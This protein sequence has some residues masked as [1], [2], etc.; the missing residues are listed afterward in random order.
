M[1]WLNQ[2]KEWLFS[3]IGVA[4]PIAI[5]SIIFKI[6]FKQDSVMM[7]QKGGRRAL[8]IVALLIGLPILLLG[9]WSRYTLSE[10]KPNKVLYDNI[11]INKDEDEPNSIY[12]QDDDLFSEPTY[13][14]DNFS[15]ESERFL[16]LYDDFV[17]ANIPISRE[18]AHMWYLVFSR[19][20]KS[21]DE[22]YYYNAIDTQIPKELYLKKFE[23]ITDLLA[24]AVVQNDDA[25]ELFL[26]CINDQDLKTIDAFFELV[27]EYLLT[28]DQAFQYELD[29]LINGYLISYYF[30]D[31]KSKYMFI[32]LVEAYYEAGVVK[33]KEGV[34]A[35][36]KDSPPGA[37]YDSQI[38]VSFYVYIFGPCEIMQR[39]SEIHQ[40]WRNST[41]YFE[42]KYE[43]ILKNKS[44]L[45]LP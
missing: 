38:N 14:V 19:I 7:T 31:P 5:I 13:E 26:T 28:N 37:D 10:N 42:E 21:D 9:M 8:L 25:R 20:E 15:I 2:N 45:R 18:D 3:G 33:L 23:E 36:H 11:S 16:G 24:T 29:R 43:F 32:K 1:D 41:A 40:A 6:I 44:L 22:L 12:E 17:A 39:C 27:D 30:S 34:N 4:V 35:L